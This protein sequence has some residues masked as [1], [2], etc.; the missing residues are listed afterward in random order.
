MNVTQKIDKLPWSLI[1]S[2]GLFALIR[3]VIKILGDVFGYEVSPLVTII[4]TVMIAMIWI[5]I[6]VG[7]K[8]KEPVV[9]LALSGV[10]YA[11]SSIVMAVAIQLSVPSLGDSEAKISTLLTAGL[12]ASI[13]FNF[14]Y[15][16]F[17]GFVALFIQKVVN[18]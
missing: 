1:L 4:I 9:V 17:L 3:P 14:M 15:G 18:K 7:L 2:L 10:M 8:I 12:A 6:I 11:V 5:G 13:I 16:A